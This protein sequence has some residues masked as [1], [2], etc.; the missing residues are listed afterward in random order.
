MTLKPVYKIKPQTWM[1]EEGVLG[2]IEALE[3]GTDLNS[4]PVVL[5]VGGCVRNTLLGI[6]V[7][8]VDL[9]TIIKPE[10]VIQILKTSG[11]TVIPTG[12]Q[13]GTVTV[14]A[15][16]KHYEITTLRYDCETDGRHAVVKYTDNWVEDARRRDFTINTLLADI[17]GNIFDPTELGFIDLNQRIIRFVGNPH[18]RIKEDYLRI[19]RFFRFHALL[20]TREFDY[21]ALQACRLEACHIHKLSKERITQEFIKILESKAPGDILDVMFSHNVLAELKFK[22]YDKNVLNS[23]CELQEIYNLPSLSSRILVLTGV[24]FEAMQT[25]DKFMIFPKLIHR[26]VNILATLWTESCEGHDASEGVI[27]YLYNQSIAEQLTL[28]KLAHNKIMTSEAVDKL[29]HIKNWEVPLF[30]LNGF[31]LKNAGIQ[32]GPKMGVILKELENWW[33]KENFIPTKKDCLDRL[34]AM[35]QL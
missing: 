34:K 5:F 33:L 12:L 7:K 20:G 35:Q 8:D 10:Q 25:F 13:H 22:D 29:S 18:D 21:A 16:E 24:K 15:G 27:T 11:F 4:K 1:T 30:P 28:I 9:A 14:L 17:K 32:P 2:V 19:L 23:F 31:D 3:A 26:E 6:T